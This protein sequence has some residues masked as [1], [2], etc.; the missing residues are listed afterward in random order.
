MNSQ[1]RVLRI[2]LRLQRRWQTVAELAKFG[3]RDL[4]TAR[5]DLATIRQAG[6][7]LRVLTE[8]FGR[9]SYRLEEQ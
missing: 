6:F 4:K 7:R 1:L 3:R 8:E 5:R 2:V 9:K